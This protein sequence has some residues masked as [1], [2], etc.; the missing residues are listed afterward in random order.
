ML[1]TRRAFGG[2]AL[3]ALG[4]GWAHP[5]F[6]Q[7][8]ARTAALQAIRAYGDA[9]LRHFGLPGLTLA[10]TTPDGFG[11]VLSFGYAD[12]ASRSAITADTLFQIGSISKLANAAMLHQLAAQQRLALDT[13]ISDLLPSIPLPAGNRITVQH[14]L[15]HVA[16]LPGDAPLFP[17]GGLWTGYAP[18]E[19]WHY[20]NTGYDILGKLLEHVSGR[21]LDLLTRERI[22]TPLGMAASRGA[23]VAPDRP[24]YAQGYEVAD[25]GTYALGAPLAPAPWID[26]TVADGNIASTGQDMIRLLRSLSDAA[27]GRGGLGLSPAAAT[28]FTTHSVES[29]TPGMRYGNGLMHV[30]YAGRHYLHHTGGMVSFSS[31]FHIDVASGAGAFASTNLSG[32][33][34]YR[35]RLLTRFAVDALTNAAAGKTLPVPP[36]LFVPS[37][38]VPA[39]LGS[40]SGPAG[41]IE[42]TAGDP[43]TISAGG[44]SARLEPAGGELFRTTHPAF[45][46]FDFL[47][48]RT[49]GRVSSVAWGPD[50]FIR[51]GSA[52]VAARPDPALAALAGRY[53][54]DDPWFGTMR[55]VERAG[56]LWYGTDTPLTRIGDNLWRVGE[57]SWSPERASF[58]DLVDGRPNTLVFSGQKFVRRDI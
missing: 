49:G 48:A 6:A 40:Y 36:S 22:F 51:A 19:H 23:I 50:T 25:G 3:A 35:P 45:R 46:A 12:A 2:G 58:Q 4:A 11:T 33:A 32:F 56:R 16:G 55:I 9:N 13:R 42:I 5:A 37:G 7:D 39:Y 14:L 8:A 24:L 26:V 30:D 52:A 29:D 10:L 34:G 47:F 44:R 53:V 18:G 38:H 31:S 17:P 43:L 1:I 57:E 27:Q 20:S 21:P 41:T 28:A 54:S 15:D